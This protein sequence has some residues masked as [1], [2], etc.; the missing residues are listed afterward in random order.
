MPG[1]NLERNRRVIAWKRNVV[2][3]DLGKQQF[4]ALIMQKSNYKRRKGHQIWIPPL[5]E[6]AWR[7]KGAQYLRNSKKVEISLKDLTEDVAYILSYLFNHHMTPKISP[8]ASWW[9]RLRTAGVTVKVILKPNSWDRNG[10]LNIYDFHDNWANSIC[11]L[12]SRAVIKQPRS[13]AVNCEAEVYWLNQTAIQ[14][15]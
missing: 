5:S 11:W 4:V 13:K 14:L 10:N 9:V 2:S 1:H 15:A 7:G 6:E 12:S 3:L 8:G